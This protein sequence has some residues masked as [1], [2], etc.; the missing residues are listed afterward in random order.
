MRALRDVI[1]GYARLEEECMKTNLEVF[2]EYRCE[3]GPV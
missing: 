3:G 1:A 2:D